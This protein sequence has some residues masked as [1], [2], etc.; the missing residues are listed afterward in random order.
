MKAKSRIQAKTR[1]EI[2]AERRLPCNQMPKY[3][4]RK[5]SGKVHLEYFIHFS[6]ALNPMDR[7]KSETEIFFLNYCINNVKMRKQG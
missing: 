6:T 2:K 4:R 1:K 3:C 5:V 7:K